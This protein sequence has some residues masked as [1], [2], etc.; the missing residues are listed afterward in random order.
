[1]ARLAIERF[2]NFGDDLV[3]GYDLTIS[4]R[5]ASN[6][7]QLWSAIRPL[8]AS[9][10]FEDD[11]EVSSQIEIKVINQAETSPGQPVNWRAVIDSKAFTE[12]NDLD[13]FM[14]YG[15]E[16][17]FMDRCRIVKWLPIFEPTGPTEFTIRAHDGRHQMQLGNQ[18]KSGQKKKKRKTFYTRQSDDQIVKQIAKK[19]GYGADTDTPKVKKKAVKGAGGK[20]QHVFPTRVQGGEQTDWD[21]LRKLAD[22]NRFDLWVSYDRKKNQHV[23]NFKERQD[24]GKPE[25]KFVYNGE[26]GSLISAQP[27]FSIQEQPTDVEVLHYDRK[28]RKI[29][30]T[31]V[32]EKNK[33][34]KVALSDSRVG[35]GQLQAKKSLIQGAAVRFRAGGQVLE[36]FNSKPF[37]SKKEAQQFVEAWLRE[38]ERDMVVMQGKVVGIPTLR[39]RQVHQLEGLGARL[40]GFYRFSN[41]KHV[42]APGSGIY[43]V[44]FTAH[45]VLSEEITRRGRTVTA[46]V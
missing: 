29:E 5:D 2:T 28:T 39:S 7:T 23:V 20:V 34:E 8:I 6:A 45:K 13:L 38:R 41:T 35:P 10:T 25:Y 31:V 11:E 22:I 4:G 12:G 43:V 46:L 32:S 30:R 33:G 16:R 15:G 24:I 14:G 27:D 36:A 26:D 37:R 40:D 18:F 42:Q 17:V 1:V 21:F 19:Y 9:V 3:P 44:E